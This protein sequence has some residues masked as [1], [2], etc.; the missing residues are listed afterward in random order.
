[1]V[2]LRYKFFWD[3]AFI[4]TPD[5]PEPILP[6]VYDPSRWPQVMQQTAP[7]ERMILWVDRCDA[8]PPLGSQFAKML[9]ATDPRH[10]R[11]LLVLNGLS[12]VLAELTLTPEVNAFLGQ[13]VAL[14]VFFVSFSA[15]KNSPGDLR[16]RMEADGAALKRL[17]SFGE[18]DA[19]VGMQRLGLRVQSVT[20]EMYRRSIAPVVL[21]QINRL[22]AKLAAD[23]RRVESQIASIQ[24]EQLRGIAS[25]Y[26]A[27]YLQHFRAALQGTGGDPAVHG[28]TLAEERAGVGMQSDLW[29]VNPRLAVVVAPGEVPHSSAKLLGKGAFLRLMSDL[30]GAVSKAPLTTSPASDAALLANSGPARSGLEPDFAFAAS[31]VASK[32]AREVLRPL[33][34]SAVLRASHIAKQLTEAAEAGAAIEQRRG[35]GAVITH[36]PFFFAM[37]RDLV[38]EFV[39]R[40]AARCTQA[41]DDEFRATAFL[42]L[43]LLRQAKPATTE[44]EE[45]LARVGV[46]AT[47]VLEELRSRLLEAARLALVEHLLEPLG[48]ELERHVVS[49]MA[50]VRQEEVEAS[51][52]PE[53]ARARL[54]EEQC[55]LQQEAALVTEYLRIFQ[56][57]IADF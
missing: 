52:E 27:H 14:P 3:M 30:S 8:E 40:H 44:E 5:L 46:M 18:Y 32:R 10:A 34:V 47:G 24:P 28:E 12:E 36:A 23:Q 9:E 11:S 42:P 20:H 6:S 57:H 26:L 43:S 33:L 15:E 49:R 54:L 37:I 39:D 41:V 56:T 31:D 55:R 21:S 7:P 48:E 4:V 25:R 17:K 53:A 50:L 19:R 2:T 1:V 51:L 29:N 35:D 16:S 45:E 38:H 13:E 22:G